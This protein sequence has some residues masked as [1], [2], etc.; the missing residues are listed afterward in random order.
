[1]GV[2]EEHSQV[3]EGAKS[4]ES[5]LRDGADLVVLNEAVE[6]RWGKWDAPGTGGTHHG[7][8]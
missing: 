6:G 4:S 2:A 3:C 5:I 8:H 1:M 7:S